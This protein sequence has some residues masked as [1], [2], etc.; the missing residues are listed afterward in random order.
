MAD[1]SNVFPV[2]IKAEYDGG[3]PFDAFSRHLENADQ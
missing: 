3:D 2:F 1:K